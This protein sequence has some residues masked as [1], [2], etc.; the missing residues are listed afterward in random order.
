M[1]IVEGPVGT[2]P[3]VSVFGDIS[4][5]RETWGTRRGGRHV[6]KRNIKLQLRDLVRVVGIGA[7]LATR[8]DV[9]RGKFVYQ[10]PAGKWTQETCCPLCPTEEIRFIETQ[11]V[12]RHRRP[13]LGAVSSGTPQESQTNVRDG[14]MWGL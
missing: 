3:V 13:V 5:Y 7:P 2:E 11:W 9:I 14:N 6:A 10:A 4:F 8:G 12:N 1:G